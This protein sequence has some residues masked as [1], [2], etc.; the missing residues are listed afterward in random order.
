MCKRFNVEIGRDWTN[1]RTE[2]C[3][4]IYRLSPW[5]NSTSWCLSLSRLL[6]ERRTMW[7]LFKL[8]F[9]VMMHLRY[10][11]RGYFQFNDFWGKPLWNNNI[12]LGHWGGG[13]WNTVCGMPQ[14]SGARVKRRRLKLCIE[15]KLLHFAWLKWNNVPLIIFQLLFTASWIN[16]LTIW[17]IL[18]LFWRM[19]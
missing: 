15:M 5:T 10:V 7:V 8:N 16:F 17:T 13:R 18:H 4:L 11:C 12:F 1:C 14:K 2:I 3:F 19:G 9:L 6:K